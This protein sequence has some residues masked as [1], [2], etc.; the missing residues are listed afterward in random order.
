MSVVCCST[1]CLEQSEAQVRDLVNI[2]QMNE[3]ITGADLR[4]IKMTMG[5]IKAVYNSGSLSQLYSGISKFF[6]TRISELHSK[7]MK[8]VVQ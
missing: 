8:S 5:M 3:S 1:Q 2:D 6:E 7:M 4:V